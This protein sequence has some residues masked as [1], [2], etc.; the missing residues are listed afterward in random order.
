[1]V[2]V[3]TPL[4]FGLDE[5]AGHQNTFHNLIDKD[6]F[7]TS[8]GFYFPYQRRSPMQMEYSSDIS[9]S[10]ARY[11]RSILSC[12]SS[13][14]HGD[15][16]TPTLCTDDGLSSLQDTDKGEIIP[17]KCGSLVPS[18][19]VG[20]D[21]MREVGQSRGRRSRGRCVDAGNQG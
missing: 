19:C 16:T 21:G 20:M 1:M 18:R 6:W 14:L 7:E 17:S 9:I 11:R 2:Q 10:D 13:I 15:H 3:I 8:V 4:R 12:I 5:Q